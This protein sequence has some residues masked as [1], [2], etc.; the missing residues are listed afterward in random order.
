MKFS[1]VV[2]TC[3][4]IAAAVQ[5]SI[6]PA[7]WGQGYQRVDPN[8]PPYLSRNPISGTLTIASTEGTQLLVQ[9]WANDLI[10]Q[11][12]N[13]KV[14]VI[15]TSAHAGLGMFLDRRTQVVAMSRA[16]TRSDIAEFVLHY[17]YEPIEV[18]VTGATWSSLDRTMA[19]VTNLFYKVKMET[20]PTPNI[21]VQS[22]RN[23]E[24]PLES[25]GPDLRVRQRRLYLYVAAPPNS[26]PGQGESELVRY[27]LSRQGQQLA[28][29]LGHVPLSSSEISR[30]RSRWSSCCNTP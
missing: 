15:P 10:I 24:Q 7:N 9:A 5:M 11:H 18:P 8:I 19:F 14:A 22:G 17:G 21:L 29:D 1:L 4:L 27:A 6:P 30:S 13:L 28:R 25:V 12:S 3:Y 23:I 26:F 16:F 2:F 20:I